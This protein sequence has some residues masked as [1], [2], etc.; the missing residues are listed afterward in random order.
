MPRFFRA[1]RYPSVATATLWYMAWQ[2]IRTKKLRS[3][4]TILGV[5][6]GLGSI[7][8]LLSIGFGLQKLVTQEVI[9]NQSVKTIDITS[10]NSSVVQLDPESAQKI[11]HLPRIERTSGLYAAAGTVQLATSEVD[12]LVY[13]VDSNY[14]DITGMVL[15]KGSFLEADHSDQAV[16]NEALLTSMGIQDPSQAI[17]KK[18]D[19][20][21][22]PEGSE[23]EQQL[24]STDDTLK[25][26]TPKEVALTVA[27]VISSGS[28]GEI[29]VPGF[30]VQQSGINSYKQLK[31]V[32]QATEDVAVVRGQIESL[33]FQ[34]RS[35]LDTISQIEQLFRYLNIILIGVGSIGMIVAILGMFNTLTISL[36]ERTREIGLMI[37]VGLRNRDVWR[38]FIHESILLSIIGSVS[39]IILASI[40]G[41]VLNIAMRGLASSRGFEEHFSVFDSPRWLAI[42]M[43]LFM[44]SIGV[45][46]AFFP[47]R[48]A[49]RISPVDA[50]RDE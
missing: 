24:S 19:L 43:I 37:S 41:T 10:P 30:I 46:V 16:V 49:S 13:G 7:F 27:G 35:P 48:R 47:A 34:T 40:G 11:E 18:L 26:A 20:T 32:V 15:V 31:V 14:K 21:I 3:T 4:L 29:Y 17:G 2:N 39:G 22:A 50:L 28:G 1:K 9:G 8:F 42:I 12:S 38:L 44:M 45:C 5:A 6:I 33:G 36:L 23:I 25:E